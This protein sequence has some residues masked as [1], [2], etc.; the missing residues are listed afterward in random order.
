[1]RL[2]P[3]ALYATALA[4]SFG[5][6]SPVP[7]A[8]DV[9]WLVNM[10]SGGGNCSLMISM[11]NL[12]QI[13]DQAISQRVTDQMVQMGGTASVQCTV[14]PTGTGSG[15]NVQ[16]YSI[17][18]YDSLQIN[19][20]NLSKTA[21]KDSPSVGSV[22]YLSDATVTS[23]SGNCNFYFSG[24]EGVDAGKVWVSFACD[25]LSNGPN[26]QTCPVVESYVAFENCLMM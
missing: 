18:G 7:A 20:P 13:N 17:E 22:T 1:M 10:S 16:G 25:G 21:T 15:F 3:V 24:N 19:I 26:G 2:A 6:S 9:A 4:A 11:R 23:F 8:P 14:A 12:G 5:C